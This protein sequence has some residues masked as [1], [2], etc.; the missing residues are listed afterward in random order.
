M[1]EGGV[2]KHWK[3][4]AVRNCKEKNGSE[5]LKGPHD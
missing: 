5:S 2:V 4:E 3:R 1:N